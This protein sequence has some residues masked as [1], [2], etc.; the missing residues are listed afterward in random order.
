MTRIYHDDEGRIL[1]AI[2]TG[3]A[4]PGTHIEMPGPAP[5]DLADWRV[6]EGAL[7][8]VVDLVTAQDRARQ[9]VNQARGAARLRYI[10]DIPGQQMV[11]ADKE[12]QAAAW[13]ADPAPDPAHYPAITAEIGITA[14][15]AHEV[16]QIYLNEA[17]LWRQISAG[18]EGVAMAAHAAIDAATTAEAC[19]AVAAG[20]EGQLAALTG[21]EAP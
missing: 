16:A 4:L 5:T 21:E 11:Y 20:I 18:I 8:R 9:A 13:L 10:T 7:V 1:Y 17:A 19:E 2:E 15:T 12:A 6:I 14:P 3:D